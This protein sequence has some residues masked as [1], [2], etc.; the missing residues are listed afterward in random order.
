MTKQRIQHNLVWNVGCIVTSGAV[1]C[2]FQFTDGAIRIGEFEY[3]QGELLPCY[4]SGDPMAL[5][6]RMVS[7]WCYLSEF[8]NTMPDPCVSFPEMP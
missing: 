5:S 1:P 7:R 4:F 8:E 3:Y 2:M 6:L